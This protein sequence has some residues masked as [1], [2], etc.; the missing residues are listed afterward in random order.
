[1]PR[2]RYPVNATARQRGGATRDRPLLWTMWSGLA[3]GPSHCRFARG[4]RAL[5]GGERL[6]ADE[7]ALE[8]PSRADP[9]LGEH[10]VQVVLGGAR[11]DEQSRADLWVR[12]PV[13]GQ[14][15]D[16]GLLGGQHVGVL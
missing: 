7:D 12:E 1:M 2:L 9:E 6:V 15:R 4:Q 14:P 16:L 10:L 13:A 3:G 8:F 5:F 11:A